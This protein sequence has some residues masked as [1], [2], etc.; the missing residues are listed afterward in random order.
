[1]SDSGGLAFQTLETLAVEAVVETAAL[2]S[3][4]LSALGTAARPVHLVIQLDAAR[5]RSRQFVAVVLRLLALGMRMK[6]DRAGA[7]Q[8]LAGTPVHF[9]LF[10][11]GDFADVR[12][13]ENC[14]CGCRPEAMHAVPAAEA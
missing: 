11:A 2:R 3:L 14:I 13:I 8:L 6:D 9:E 5:R 4:P 1:M 7:G 10:F 12:A